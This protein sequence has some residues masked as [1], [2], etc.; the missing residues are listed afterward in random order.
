M[1]KSKNLVKVYKPDR[2]FKKAVLK[3][4]VCEKAVWLLENV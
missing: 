2:L 1:S 4:P 3:K